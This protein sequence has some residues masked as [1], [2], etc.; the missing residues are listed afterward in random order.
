SFATVSGR[1]PRQPLGIGEAMNRPHQLISVDRAEG[2]IAARLISRCPPGT[3][4]V[5]PG[6]EIT[7]EAIAMIKISGVSEIY[8][9]K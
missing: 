3:P 8:V 9:V 4:V 7:Q 5:V 6:E 1:L 2:R